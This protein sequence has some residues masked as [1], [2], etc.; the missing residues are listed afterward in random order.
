MHPPSEGIQSIVSCAILAVCK[1]LK[2]TGTLPGSTCRELVCNPD[3]HGS[4]LRAQDRPGYVPATASDDLLQGLLH[5]ESPA[6]D[7][8][9]A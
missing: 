9:G 4:S 8:L 7:Y 3:L 6:T 1:T 5:S 2:S